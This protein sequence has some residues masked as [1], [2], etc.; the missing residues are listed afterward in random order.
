MKE[1]TDD[2]LAHHLEGL[3]EAP[4]E[5]ALRRALAADPALRRRLAALEE[6]LAPPIPLRSPP[7]P[8]GLGPRVL[9][10]LEREGLAG[11]PLEAPAGLRTALLTRLE[12]EGLVRPVRRRGSRPLARRAAFAA[13][14]LLS[15]ALG[16]LGGHQLAGT[17]VE[18]IEVPVERLVE[19]VVEKEVPVEIVIERLVERPVERVVEKFVERSVEPP[20]EPLLELAGARDAYLWLPDE[21]SWRALEPGGRLAS[22]DVIRGWPEGEVI[23][24]GTRQRLGSGL[25]VVRAGRLAPIPGAGEA[26]SPA[27]SAGSPEPARSIDERVPELLRALAIGSAPERA[28]AQA[29]LRRLWSEYGPLETSWLESLGAMAAPATRRGDGPPRSAEE[30]EAWWSRARQRRRGRGGRQWSPSGFPPPAPLRGKR[31][32]LRAWTLRGLLAA[33][34]TAAAAGCSTYSFDAA[35]RPDGSYEIAVLMRDL[36]A[37]KGRSLEETR[38]IPFVVF[39]EKVF[40]KQPAPG[41]RPSFA[42]AVAGGLPP[43]REGLPQGF[44]FSEMRFAGPFAEYTIFRESFYDTTGAAYEAREFRSLLSRLWVRERTAVKTVYGT[45]VEVRHSFLF[46]FIPFIFDKVEYLRQEDRG[47]L[48]EAPTPSAS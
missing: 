27:G 10:R 7:P 26:P 3:L 5:E 21:G 33:L 25:H 13:A 8:P 22:G 6:V 30:W 44:R 23:A 9:E 32:R 16:A 2:D 18:R 29:D 24:G 41:S 12:V 45:R 11:P 14:F 15:A 38:W 37:A 43:H 48:Q 40:M 46:G 17:S 19:K 4:D 28:R 31:W 39:R 35:R 20:A 34:L 36:E 1:F 47:R 42:A